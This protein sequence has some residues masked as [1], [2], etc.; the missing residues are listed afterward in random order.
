MPESLRHVIDKPKRWDSAFDPD[1]DQKTAAYILTVEPL[2]Q[3]SSSSFPKNL[4]LKE[5]ILND[6][7]LRTYGKG[8]IV[9]RQGDYGNSAFFVIKGSV[10]VVLQP[11]LPAGELGRNKKR[12][13]SLWQQFLN[14]I[15]VSKESEVLEKAYSKRNNTRL[16]G[17]KRV[18]LNDIPRVLD[19][20]QTAV[21]GEG[22]L[23]GELTA[24]SRLP[25]TATIFAEEEGTELIEVRWQGFRDIL[26]YSSDLQSYVDELYRER[27]LDS[28]FRSIPI[29][30]NLGKEAL[31]QLKKDAQ[32][33]TFGEY[34]WSGELKRLSAEERKQ[35]FV[36]EEL[37][38][39]ED[40]Y[41]NGI[42]MIRAGFARL[43]CTKGHGQQTV[44]YLGPGKQYGYYELINNWLYPNKTVNYL[45]TMSVLGYLHTIFIPTRAF[46]EHVLP[47]L[48]E[49]EY[50]PPIIEKH[51]KQR[52]GLSA[53]LPLETLE[54]FTENHLFNGQKAMVIDMDR[55]TRCDDCVRACES[56]HDGNPRFLRQGPQ[57]SNLMVA[58]ACMHCSDPVCLLG[59]PTGAIYHDEGKKGEVVINPN[60]CIG[61][62]ICESNCPYNAIRMVE[63]RSKEGAFLVDQQ[64]NPI[65]KATKC[66]FCVEQNGGPA[67]VRACPHDALRRLNLND[68][69]SDPKAI[70]FLTR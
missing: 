56:T 37:V 1:M 43:S 15:K 46:E 28:Y 2:S 19:E 69:A 58:N 33:Y 18:F 21:I 7:A 8:E 44:T 14:G 39:Q 27:A 41:P 4:P 10:R 61:C 6:C 20:Q 17:E 34:S 25:R 48:P 57:T 5:I 13:F 45:Y 62:G 67:C 70:D 51:D 12:K 60:T 68:L 54:F 66:D 16:V 63:P 35:H 31:E 65:L 32:F 26:K 11:G 36:K 23:F 38:V 50:P 55:C 53:R 22:E 24:I 29:F 9:V 42:F 52:K 59:C 30:K 40:E 3:L 64:A 47:T 49:E